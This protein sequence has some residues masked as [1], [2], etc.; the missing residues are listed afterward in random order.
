MY[1]KVET[2]SS[3]IAVLTWSVNS[4]KRPVCDTAILI[5]MVEAEPLPKNSVESRRAR[6]RLVIRFTCFASSAG[7]LNSPAAAAR[8]SSSSESRPQEKLRRLASSK[9]SRAFSGP[10]ETSLD[11]DKERRRDEERA[12]T[13]GRIAAVVNRDGASA[14]ASVEA[15]RLVFSV[16]VSGRRPGAAGKGNAIVDVAGSARAAVFRPSS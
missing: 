5:E 4:G 10:R 7:V 14:R 13:G 9:P 15:R 11:T 6:R 12:I 8:R 3:Y 1:S 2:A 16:A